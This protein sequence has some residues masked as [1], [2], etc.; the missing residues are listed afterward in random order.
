MIVASYRVLLA[1]QADIRCRQ[2]KQA[3]AYLLKTQPHRSEPRLSEHP[4]SL[5]LPQ[6]CFQLGV[7]LLRKKLFTQATRNLEK[8]K[9]DWQ[10]DPEELAQVRS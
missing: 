5:C 2:S 10:G 7:I 8:A 6:D 9:K 1:G 4:L 3:Y